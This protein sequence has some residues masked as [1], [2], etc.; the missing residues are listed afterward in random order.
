MSALVEDRM[1]VDI[2]D[3]SKN[4]CQSQKKNI[5][6]GL[7][8]SNFCHPWDLQS[9]VYRDSFRYN[10]GDIKPTK[11]N[12]EKHQNRVENYTNSIKHWKFTLETPVYHIKLNVELSSAHLSDKLK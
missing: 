3:Y 1:I 7:T 4:L 8:F 12:K 5:D 11:Y 10:K 9:I 6:L 2:H